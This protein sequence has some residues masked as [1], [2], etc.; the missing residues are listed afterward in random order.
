M[1]TWLGY[2][3]KDVIKTFTSM[4]PLVWKVKRRKVKR[5][6]KTK[7]KENQG[8]KVDVITVNL[9]SG[10]NEGADVRD[11]KRLQIMK[12]T[13]DWIKMWLLIMKQS[14]AYEYTKAILKNTYECLKC[15]TYEYT[16]QLVE[17]LK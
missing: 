6:K 17:R 1:F 10:G 4:M 2:F 9:S 16:Q 12:S 7:Q 5:K 15:S 3:L 14:S 13:D 11:Y 8:G